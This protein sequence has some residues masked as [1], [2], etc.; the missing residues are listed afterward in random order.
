VV[1]LA[2]MPLHVAEDTFAR[3]NPPGVWLLLFGCGG[4]WIGRGTPRSR[5][6]HTHSLPLYRRL[7]S[8]FFVGFCFLV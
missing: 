8:F 6:A 4:H 7:T 3:V 2:E 1:D 5:C